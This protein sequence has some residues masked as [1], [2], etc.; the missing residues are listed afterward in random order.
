M[1]QEGLGVNIRH[2]DDSP[3]EHLAHREPIPDGVH[4]LR[5]SRGVG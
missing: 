3:Y 5:A 4:T 1:M 2:W